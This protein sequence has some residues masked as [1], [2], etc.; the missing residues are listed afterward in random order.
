MNGAPTKVQGVNRS[1]LP[2]TPFSASR[3]EQKSSTQPATRFGGC[4]RFSFL[5]NASTFRG[6]LA[7]TAAMEH[8]TVFD[9]SNNGLAPTPAA[10]GTL[11]TPFNGATMSAS[12]VNA[13]GYMNVTSMVRMAAPGHKRHLAGDDIQ[14]TGTGVTDLAFAGVP[15][16]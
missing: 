15:T 12:P 14:V 7:N 5:A 1:R 13:K 11:T 6:G 10:Y 8:F 2:L 9:S 3:P 16:A 4:H